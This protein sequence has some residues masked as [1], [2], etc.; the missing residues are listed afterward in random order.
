MPMQILVQPP[1]LTRIEDDADV[2]PYLAARSSAL[3]PGLWLRRLRLREKR[4]ACG[5]AEEHF[6]TLLLQQRFEIPKRPRLRQGARRILGVLHAVNVVIHSHIVIHRLQQRPS[7][8][9]AVAFA[10]VDVSLR[11][12]DGRRQGNLSF[13]FHFCVPPPAAAA[14]AGGCCRRRPCRCCLRTRQDDRQEG[15]ALLVAEQCPR[16]CDAQQADPA[17]MAVLLR[18]EAA[19]CPARYSCHI[20][21]LSAGKRTR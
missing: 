11:T 6:L 12:Q 9:A 3:N 7:P 19:V 14:A 21:R 8:A 10:Q 13:N 5:M 2:K 16:Q 18:E 4:P 17:A 15:C 1:S 20:L